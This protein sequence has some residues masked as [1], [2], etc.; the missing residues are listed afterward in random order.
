[1]QKYRIDNLF[2]CVVGVVALVGVVCDALLDKRFTDFGDGLDTD[3]TVFGEGRYKDNNGTFR[4][5]DFQIAGQC[6][7]GRPASLRWF[8]R[9]GVSGADKF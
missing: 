2:V 3:P 9:G 5:L 8:R 6:N 7:V 4:Y 1:M